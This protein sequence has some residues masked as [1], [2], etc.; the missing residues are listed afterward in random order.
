MSA[1]LRM[2]RLLV[3]LGALASLG[4]VEPA[5]ARFVVTLEQIGP[6][7]V[8]TG[9]G[10]INPTGLTLTIS[11]GVSKTPG[12]NPGTGN[13]VLG[14]LS[15]G[16]IDLYSGITGPT[17]FG[18]FVPTSISS[19]NGDVA[20]I[21]GYFNNLMVPAG[22]VSGS[23]LSDSATYDSAT[24]ASLGVDAGTYTW[25]WGSGA[26]ADSFVLE[27]VPEPASLALFGTGLLGL[28]LIRPRRRKGV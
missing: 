9:S 20:G 25:T 16:S 26:N 1:R 3:G 12:M 8:A 23:A 21:E 13:V 24:F 19:G 27:T 22:Y 5:Q 28:G 7:V 14:P 17:N 15:G 11:G 4:L 6:N 18:I 10:S 2:V